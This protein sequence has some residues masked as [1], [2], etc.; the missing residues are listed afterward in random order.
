MG[1][2]QAIQELEEELRREKEQWEMMRMRTELDGLRQ[3]ED[4]QQQFDREHERH[5]GG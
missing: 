3:L 4:V 5:K 2:S 1:K